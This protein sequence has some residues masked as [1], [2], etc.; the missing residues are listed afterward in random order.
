MLADTSFT[1]L[2]N[3]FHDIQQ[4]AG[5]LHFEIIEHHFDN[6]DGAIPLWAS[7][8]VM[9]FGSLSKISKNLKTENQS[10]FSILIQEYKFKHTNGNEVNLSKAMFTSWIQAVLVMGTICAH[11]SRIYNRAISL[12]SSYIYRCNKVLS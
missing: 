11:H 4:V 7:L 10:V 12:H 1:L 2:N 6:H 3:R 5:T 9:S 8:E